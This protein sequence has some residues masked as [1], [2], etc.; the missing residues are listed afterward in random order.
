MILSRDGLLGAETFTHQVVSQTLEVEI[1]YRSCPLY[2]LLNK[3]PCSRRLTP[4]D[5]ALGEP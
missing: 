2:H 1:T 3:R 5:M 4:R